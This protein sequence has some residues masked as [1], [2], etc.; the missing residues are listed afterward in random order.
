M[1][2]FK[3]NFPARLYHLFFTNFV[4]MLCFVVGFFI[5]MF[6]SALLST[7][8]YFSVPFVELSVNESTPLFICALRLFVLLLW[9]TAWCCDGGVVGSA[10]PFVAVVVVIIAAFEWLVVRVD[11][12]AAADAFAALAIVTAAVLRFGVGVVD[13]DRSLAMWNCWCKWGGI[14][15]LF[16]AGWMVSS[17]NRFL[18]IIGSLA[19]LIVKISP[20]HVVWNWTIAANPFHLAICCLVLVARRKIGVNTLPVALY[21]HWA[22]IQVAC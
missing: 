10:D 11:A 2:L 17:W 16:R 9:F 4:L 8:T 22:C 15:R 3:S 5:F 21:A 1:F 14:S 20:H 7:Y 13:C 6:V 12:L 18:R 19:L